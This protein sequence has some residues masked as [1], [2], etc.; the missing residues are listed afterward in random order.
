MNNLIRPWNLV[1]FAG[2]IVYCS[3]RGV[4]KGRAERHEKTVRR[5][6]AFERILL[7]FVFAGALL[8]PA[9]YL[10]TPWL[11][12][13]DYRLPASVQWCGTLLMPPALLLFYRSHADLGENWS[14]TLELRQGHQLVTR[15]VYKSIRH[16]MYAAIFLWD[17]AQGFLLENWLA[18]WCA[19][20]TF[21]ILYLVRTPREERMMREFFGEEYLDYTRQTGRL[22]PP[23][24]IA[25]RD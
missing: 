9:L 24:R 13:T 11:G 20:F 16:P 2:F 23:P 4:F 19:L 7:S 3:I 25:R 14:V 21:A 8:L 6:D 5:L 18:G 22:L 1:F 12:F 10:F 17:I 15:G